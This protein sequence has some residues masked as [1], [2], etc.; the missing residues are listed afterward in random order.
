MR[1]AVANY[2]REKLRC[3]RLRVRVGVGRAVLCPPLLGAH[4]VTLP[5]KYTDALPRWGVD[6]ETAEQRQNF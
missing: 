3:Q 1:L 5:T 4:G 2:V 6:A